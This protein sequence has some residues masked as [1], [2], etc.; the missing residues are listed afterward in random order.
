MCPSWTHFE[1]RRH[2]GEA[3]T[4][5]LATRCARSG[6]L[7]EYLGTDDGFPAPEE[8]GGPPW[9]SWYPPGGPGH[10]QRGPS[11]KRR[12]R[13]SVGK[14]CREWFPLFFPFSGIVLNFCIN[15]VNTKAFVPQLVYISTFCKQQSGIYK[16]FITFE[17]NPLYKWGR[18][19]YD[20]HC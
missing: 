19:Y 11:S 16:F 2:I 17:K 3:H 15:Q 4:I 10:R 12:Q 14:S 7:L 1:K 6:G 9:R 13:P 8:S 18:L 20:N 5:R